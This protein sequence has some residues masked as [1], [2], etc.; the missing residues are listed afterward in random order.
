LS[1]DFSGRAGGGLAGFAAGSRVAGYLLEEQIGS[2][3][4]AV[5]F[6]AVDE[7]LGR[8][9]ALKVLS[10][11][12]AADEAFRTRFIR[13]SRAAAAVDDPHIIPVYEAGDTGGVLFIAMR[14]VPGGDAG[15][16]VDRGGRLPAARATAIISAVASA[17]DS[18]HAAGL[19]HRDVKPANMLVDVR[20]GRADH[21]YLSDFGL[22]KPTMS[23]LDLTGSGIF[24]GTLSYA[25]PEQIEGRAVDAR[26][27]Q[28]SLGCAAFELLS[29]S[30]PFVRTQPAAMIWAHVSDPP[31]A[32]S[33]L[34]PGLG[35]AADTVLA[36]ALAKEPRNRFASCGEF[37]AALTAALE[38]P[39]QAPAL[40]P[41]AVAP[42][43]V[44]PAAI[45]PPPATPGGPPR[46][47]RLKAGIAA[48]AAVA[49]AA[50]VI[51]IAVGRLGGSDAPVA[52]GTLHMVAAYGPDNLD[53]VPAYYA[54]DYVLERAYA[55]QLVSY[56]TVPDPSVTSAGWTADT[57][58]VADVAA[59]VPTVANGGISGGGLT[60]TFHLRR[61]V[62]W[63]TSPARPV[64]AT[65]FVREFKAFCNPVSPVGNLTYYVERIR[66][67]RAYCAAEH[68][69]FAGAAPTGAS[70][71]GF[72]DSH[73]IAG[74]TAVDP[75][76]LRFSLNAPTAD[77]LY[78]LALPFT[79][80]R[81]AEYDQYVPGSPL[82]S[83]HT[84]SDGP[85][86]VSSYRPGRSVTLSRNPAWRQSADPVR[87]QF[88]RR[89]V[90]TMGVSDP[91][92][93][94]AG[95]RSGKY[96]L[97]LEAGL[98][99]GEI[100]ALAASGDPRFRLWPGSNSMPYLVFNLRSPS[101]GRAMSSLAVRQAVEFG[102]D[103][104]AVQAVLGGPAAAQ[105]VSTVI[106][107]GNLGYQAFNLYPTRRGAGDPA[108]CRTLLARAGYAS[109]LTVRYWY[110]DDSLSAAVFRSV[111][112][113]LGRCGIRLAGRPEPASR[114]LA[115]LSN[116]HAN[117]QPGSFD[118]AQ[119]E[120]FPD[121]FGD[122]GRAI[123]APLLET[124]CDTSTSNYGCYSSPRVDSLIGRAEAAPTSAAAAPLWHQADVQ[125]M[126]DA[127]IA[128][129]LS[130][131]LPAY[132][133]A[134]VR[135]YC[136]GSGSC[137]AVVVT[138]TIGGPDIT[139][140]WLAP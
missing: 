93:Q 125:A 108:R 51:A 105:I 25:S 13:E 84:I 97:A 72:Q 39:A 79:S 55:R 113:S 64:M 96:D 140:L 101:D 91:R 129:L 54:P 5:V 10:P 38:R 11:V 42:A 136:P 23:S 76:T 61:G 75:L 118:V 128:P 99:P 134:R 33:S 80:A 45:G 100:A 95:E 24:I 68:A 48:G 123:I 120:W 94:V 49:V 12:L 90:V 28:Y 46:T 18:A 6:R 86:Q 117:N 83:Q 30:P 4:M 36:R 138:P 110:P 137:P 70:I 8:R 139:S 71:A 87:H 112:T 98:P 27:D 131:S 60:Y 78:T 19:V 62:M 29:G 32:L 122:N 69:H 111:A 89:I 20:P 104:R 92:A 121:W 63:N 74:I 124:G 14:F 65:D 116:A 34:V 126:R 7:R 43:V 102:L 106:P 37:A 40:A 103:K 135:Q 17:L 26:A 50:A 107:P 127:V 119:A 35:L 67:M 1:D 44:S 41:E 21:V 132:S 130:Q 114:L 73:A 57:T 81:P 58:P 109:G 16:L 22:S 31:P 85:Y 59:V 56:P 47:R 115:D 2:G 53:T 15:Q 52:G 82:L 133:S 3:G 77:F 9:V 88:V 66:G